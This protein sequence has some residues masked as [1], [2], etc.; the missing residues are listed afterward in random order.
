M[1]HPI[2][3]YDHS[4]RKR[5]CAENVACERSA[6]LKLLIYVTVTFVDGFL[7]AVLFGMLLRAILSYFLDESCA[8]MSFLALVTEPFI[9]PV[10][11][12]ID[13]FDLFGGSP[14]DV[15]FFLTCALI[16]LVRMILTFVPI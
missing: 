2:L 3:P 7:A 1:R 4:V 9:A 11:S 13:R 15:S 5:Q 10:R 6:V 14:I 8:L 16:A 12:I